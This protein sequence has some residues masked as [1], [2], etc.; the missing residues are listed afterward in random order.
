MSKRK[1]DMRY[2]GPFLDARIQQ[3]QKEVKDLTGADI[4]YKEAGERL[5]SAK[6]IIL[7]DI[8]FQKGKKKKRV[9]IDM[10]KGM[11]LI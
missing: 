10:F 8:T 6:P 2:I 1:G 5:A 9:G 3:T 11:G 4:G 7:P